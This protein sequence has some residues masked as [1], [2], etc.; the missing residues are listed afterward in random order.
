MNNDPEL[1]AVIDQCRQMAIVMQ[2]LGETIDESSAAIVGFGNAIRAW[3]EEEL[4][5]LNDIQRAHYLQLI[6]NGAYILP[7]L[8]E[9]RHFKP[10]N[11]N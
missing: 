9:A 5:S 8:N 2:K 6:Q 10:I 1:V 7:A 4:Q 11:K 3:V